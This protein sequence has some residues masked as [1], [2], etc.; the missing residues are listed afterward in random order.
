MQVYNRHDTHEEFL[1]G[2]ERSHSLEIDPSGFNIGVIG[3]CESVLL[4]LFI[5]KSLGSLHSA[6]A[7][8]YICIDTRQ[9]S[10]DLCRCRRH[11]PASLHYNKNEYRYEDCNDESKSPLHIKHEA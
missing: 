11:A 4:D 2:E 10:L 7:R 9:F 8:L 1:S 5:G 6:E 3:M